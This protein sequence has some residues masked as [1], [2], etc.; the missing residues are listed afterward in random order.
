M[1][2]FTKKK[3][4]LEVL[5]K[6]E[7]IQAISMDTYNESLTIQLKLPI[8]DASSE[9]STMQRPP[10]LKAEKAT[11][12]YVIPSLGLIIPGELDR[13]EL[14]KK[15]KKICKMGQIETDCQ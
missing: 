8:C 7:G 4:F 9:K 1:S 6:I 5:R 15:R 12:L 3:T 14:K 13:V 10:W 11:S 2:A